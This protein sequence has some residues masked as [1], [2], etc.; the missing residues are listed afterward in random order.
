M[1]DISFLWV[2]VAVGAILGT[3][4]FFGISVNP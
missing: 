1:R 3:L 2:L 4:A